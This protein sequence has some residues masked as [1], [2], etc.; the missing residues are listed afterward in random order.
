MCSWEAWVGIFNIVKKRHTNRNNNIIVWNSVELQTVSVPLSFYTKQRSK[1]RVSYRTAA[2]ELQRICYVCQGHFIKPSQLSLQTTMTSWPMRRCRSITSL[3]IVNAPSLWLVLQTAV[4]M[5]CVGGSCPLNRKSLPLQFHVSP[6][7]VKA[8]G[9][10]NIKYSST[11]SWFQSNWFI[12]F[13]GSDTTRNPRIHER[14]GREYH[15]VSRPAF[16]T[17]LAAGKFIESGEYGKNLYGTSTDS[18]RHVIN[19]GRI[20]L[21][22]LHTRVGD[23]AL[24]T[25][26]TILNIVSV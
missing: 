12:L 9:H 22:C 13:H 15:F 1:V 7:F 26:R 23:W 4:T 11:N 21:L 8:R 5:S 17:D 10:D 6:R 18:V 19:S 14:N 24:V 16:E 3:P 2:Q 25:V 20:C